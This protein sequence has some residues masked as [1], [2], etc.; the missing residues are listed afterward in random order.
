MKR[1][2]AHLCDYIVVAGFGTKNT[3]AVK[4][5]IDLGSDPPDIVVIDT[6]DDRARGQGDG[7]HR[8]QGRCDP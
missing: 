3:R 2:P 4:E 7:L 8:A 5:L 1:N 6:N